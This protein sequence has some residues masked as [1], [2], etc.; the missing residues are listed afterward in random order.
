MDRS[1]V[2][3][4]A[5]GPPYSSVREVWNRT[6]VSK[7]YSES[8]EVPYALP[9]ERFTDPRPLPENYHYEDKDYV[10]ETKREYLGDHI[11][12]TETHV[13]CRLLSTRQ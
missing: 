9:P 3:G 8:I 13:M 4:Q 2:A 6:G 10:Y 7:P 11:M 5:T 12:H 1:G